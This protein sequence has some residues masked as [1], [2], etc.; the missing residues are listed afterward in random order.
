MLHSQSRSEQT[1]EKFYL[2]S[3][4]TGA[5]GAD[6]YD[7]VY[8]LNILTSLLSIHSTRSIEKRT[9]F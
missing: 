8:E 3:Y 1:F 5:K 7:T 2:S 6:S 9:D 4:L